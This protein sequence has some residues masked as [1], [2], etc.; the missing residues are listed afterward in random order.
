MGLRRLG[1]GL[2]SMRSFIERQSSFG[3]DAWEAA[4]SSGVLGRGTGVLSFS[5]DMQCSYVQAIVYRSLCARIVK[6]RLLQFR[7]LLVR[8]RHALGKSSNLS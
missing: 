1:G 8:F 3:L 7:V 2:V 5:F 6:G 4:L